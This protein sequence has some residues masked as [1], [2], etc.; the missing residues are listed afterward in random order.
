MGG[1]TQVGE[2]VA[3]VKTTMGGEGG[4]VG[5]RGGSAGTEGDCERGTGVRVDADRVRRE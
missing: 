5:D 4:S 2:E 3:R 1:D